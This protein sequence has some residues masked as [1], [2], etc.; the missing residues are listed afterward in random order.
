[1]INWL[2]DTNTLIWFFEGSSRLNPILHL[3]SIKGTKIYISVVSWWEIAVKE[4]KGKLSFT[5]SQLES[6][7]NMYDF[8]E[9]P[10]TREQLKAYRELP[11]IHND[12]FDHMLL[13]QAIT[14]P[15]RL[16]TGDAIL[17]D[18]SSLVMVI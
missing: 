4:R 15:M 2:L 14:C 10:V 6:F 1:M 3:F 13:A 16:I 8:Q 12:P 18:Y 5:G 11:H 9:L 17:A 7:V